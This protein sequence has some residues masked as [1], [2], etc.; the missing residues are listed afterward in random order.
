MRVILLD[1]M[2]KLG[3]LGDQVPVK[4]GYAR[5]FLIPQGKAVLAT[6]KNLENFMAQRADQEKRLV[7]IMSL[8]KTTAEKIKALE[9]IEIYS[10]AGAEGKLFGSVGAR[11]IA[12][13]IKKYGINVTKSQV[14]LS[15]GFIRTTGEYKVILQLHREVWTE[16]VVNVL[17][18]ES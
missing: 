8:A 18:A 7:E 13:T 12:D 14:K 1:K 9:V 17:S 3:E 16:I 15:D 10:N 4:S 11:D 6:K 5:N 2:A